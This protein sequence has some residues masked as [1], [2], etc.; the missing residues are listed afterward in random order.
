MKDPIVDEIHKTRE[1]I[2]ARLKYNARALGDYLR[3]RERQ[4]KG[5]VV[6]LSP[7]KRPA[8]SV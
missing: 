2:A 7:K 4:R 3:G 5:R 1:K 8:V 6:C